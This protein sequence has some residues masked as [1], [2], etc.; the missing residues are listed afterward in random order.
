MVYVSP[1]D[2][3]HKANKGRWNGRGEGGKRRI[4]V[5][6]GSRY[7]NHGVAGSREGNEE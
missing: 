4:M 2:I 1:E 3:Q 6:R 7:A 5:V